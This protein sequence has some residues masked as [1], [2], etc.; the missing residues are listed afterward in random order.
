MSD[1]PSFATRAAFCSASLAQ[2][3]GDVLIERFD[4]ASARS[5]AVYVCCGNNEPAHPLKARNGDRWWTIRP[6][7]L[8]LEAAGASED[9]A[10]DCTQAMNN[11]LDYLAATRHTRLR[12][13]ARDYVLASPVRLVQ[14]A[15]DPILS[16]AIEG[17]G[18][19]VSRLVVPSAESGAFSVSFASDCSEFLASDFSLI[20][21]G[22][23]DADS[24]RGTAILARF[25][26]TGEAAPGHRSA[27]LS[28]LGVRD[29]G[30]AF[31]TA[32]DLAGATGP[33]VRDCVFI[34]GAPSR[35][36]RGGVKSGRG[37]AAARL[38]EGV[39]A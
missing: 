21:T 12:L 8:S 18:R 31:E 16:F 6:D 7:H 4:T 30:A 10:A 35:T 9:V 19:K 38:P 17:C 39:G 37:D 22:R 14:R 23:R 27:V 1:R 25:A 15:G 3:T 36:A 29:E 24:G 2:Y 26:R 33:L 5:A 11:V 20:A 34:A 28:S 32:I 13:G